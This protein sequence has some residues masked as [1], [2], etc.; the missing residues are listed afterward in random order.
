MKTLDICTS[1]ANWINDLS[2]V[3]LDFVRS[4]YTWFYRSSPHTKVACRLDSTLGNIE[5]RHQFLEAVIRLLPHNNSDHIPLIIDLRGSFEIKTKDL[6][7]F[8]AAWFSDP[9]FL[10]F[11]LVC[12]PL[13]LVRDVLRLDG[14]R[15]NIR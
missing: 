15:S 10:I 8:L 7:R 4:Q 1:F 5:W 12:S 14:P 3:D 9:N 13:C 11:L 6:F 2:L